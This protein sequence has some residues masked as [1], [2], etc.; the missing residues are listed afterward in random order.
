MQ[1]DSK[2]NGRFS[3]VVIVVAIVVVVIAIVWYMYFS[4][5]FKK[6]EPSPIVTPPVT[7]Q[8]AK[9]DPQFSIIGKS[10]EG[11]DIE[12]YTFGKGPTHLALVGGIHG[13]YEWNAVLVAYDTIDY[14]KLHPEI[15]PSNMTVTIIPNVNPDGLFKI[16]GTGGRFTLADV[17]AGDNTTGV[18]RFNAN[19]VDLNRNFDCKWQPQSTWRSHVESAGSAVFSEPESQALR[20]FVEKFK[21]ASVVFWHSQSG[22]VYASQCKN[23][24]L[25]DTIDVMNTYAKASGYKA[26][27]VFDAY[28]TTGDAD[29]WLANIGIPAVT[30]ELTTHND[31]E[32]DKNLAGVGALMRYY[33][34]K[35]ENI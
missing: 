24:I 27:K 3:W 17:P 7:T 4:G 2:S 14:F 20:D 6:S 29:S 5:F 31:V 16:V 10:V 32:F 26:V 23:G 22:A 34:K 35:D 1:N 15:I 8:I 11:R 9:P 21:P 30:V 25:P 13:G 19:N 28:Q 18:G 12:S 33:E